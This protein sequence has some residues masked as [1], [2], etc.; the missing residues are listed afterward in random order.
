MIWPLLIP[1]GLVAWNLLRV[2]KAAADLLPTVTGYR[3][4]SGKIIV[5]LQLTNPTREDLYIN[6]VFLDLIG[7]NQTVG[8]IRLQD[9]AKTFQIPGDQSRTFDVPVTPLVG[10]LVTAILTHL[11]SGGTAPDIRVSGYIRANEIRVPIDQTIS[12]LK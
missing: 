6:Y 5:L 12:F 10:S 7:G 1:A 3:F 8:Q 4:R 2:G 9:Q 11:A